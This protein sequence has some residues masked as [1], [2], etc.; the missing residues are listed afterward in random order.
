MGYFNTYGQF[1][2]EDELLHYGVS[3]LD[4]AK[5]G[6]GRYPLG[7]GDR[8]HQHDGLEQEA[9]IL[10]SGSAPKQAGSSKKSSGKFVDKSTKASRQ[11]VLNTTVRDAR[12]K[13]SNDDLKTALKIYAAG[14]LIIGGYYLYNH[15]DDV[16]AIDRAK[17]I[18]SDYMSGDIK[19]AINISEKMRDFTPDVRKTFDSLVE[20]GLK[21]LDK[22][23]S[24]QE[25]I[26]KV[27]PHFY[28]KEGMYNC[29]SCSLASVLR[30]K[31]GLDVKA[32]DS[33]KGVQL[34]EL[35]KVVKN[36]ENIVQMNS[37]KYGG[38][39]R[40][41]NYDDTKSFLDNA[42]NLLLKNFKDGAQGFCTVMWEPMYGGGGH[43]FNWLIDN[44]KVMWYDA[45][46]G[47]RNF[48]ENTKY[49]NKANAEDGFTA[50]RLDNADFDMDLLK[51]LVKAA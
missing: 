50:V 51:K 45:Q 5:E 39:W 25:S 6:S 17:D 31:F 16:G 27:N 44:G 34:S 38:L 24:F 18:V 49:F 48:V 36:R 42:E 22:F 12:V 13:Q 43:A 2:Y 23:E 32:I 26:R 10:N 29:F 41:Y 21:P 4:G 28:K 9:R 14:A 11:A 20:N 8:P 47:V 7:S 3:K 30:T 35:L 40:A 15:L 19:N 46:R 1:V 37:S 33:T